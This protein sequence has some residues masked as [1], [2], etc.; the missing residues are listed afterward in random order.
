MGADTFY[1]LRDS[2][3]KEK[4]IDVQF[5]TRGLLDHLTHLTHLTI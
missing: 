3:A 1:L 4:E 2:Y 5:R